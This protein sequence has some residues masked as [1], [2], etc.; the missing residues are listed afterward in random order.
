MDQIDNTFNQ[1]K[2]TK[3]STDRRLRQSCSAQ[4]VIEWSSPYPESKQG[5][6]KLKNSRKGPRAQHNHPQFSCFHSK[7]YVW[8]ENVLRISIKYILI[9]WS[10]FEFFF[11]FLP[12][13]FCTILKTWTVKSFFMIEKSNLIFVLWCKQNC[14]VLCIITPFSWRM[15]SLPSLAAAYQSLFCF[16]F[17]V[18][19]GQK[20]SAQKSR[21]IQSNLL[22]TN[23][24]PTCGHVQINLTT[25]LTPR[26]LFMN[27]SPISQPLEPDPQA[28]SKEKE[29]ASSSSTWHLHGHYFFL[30]PLWN[31]SLNFGGS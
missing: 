12:K 24:I 17:A 28:E 11:F 1:R 10:L 18:Y 8:I 7:Y 14:Y 25:L 6:S 13:T 21:T 20:S 3:M 22:L 15:E 5:Q 16:H 27:R 29:W 2:K 26:V 31:P 30:H 9:F 23:L 19:F 4:W